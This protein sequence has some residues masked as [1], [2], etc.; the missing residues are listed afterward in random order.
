MNTLK[1][2]AMASALWFAAQA[3]GQSTIPAPQ[4]TMAQR[5]QACTICHG[6]QGR[7]TNQG[8]FPRIAGKPAAY[9]SNQLLNFR[10]GRRANAAMIYLVE[11]MSD[12]YIHEIGQYF[13]ALE[14]PYP[15]P[16]AP[17]VDAQALAHG[18]TLALEGDK[19]RAIP[20]CV[21]C[22]GEKMTG[23]LPAFPGL[24][25]LPPDY[26]MAQF[27]AWRTG[28]RKAAAPDC[29]HEIATRLNAQDIQA[30]AHWLAAQPVP[31]DSKPAARLP[32]P[33]PMPCGSGL[34]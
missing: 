21:Q 18:R 26:L 25:G 19:A 5:M 12:A 28:Q 23:V 27:G 8:Y 30:V 24:L 15:P 2:I 3:H 31:P 13:G 33:V 10:D 29:M 14:L 7:A 32:A 22:H 11:H 20:A 17:A 6:Q 9:L 16:V 34:Q 4:D 1:S